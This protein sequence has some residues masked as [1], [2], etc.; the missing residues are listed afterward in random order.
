ME[1]RRPPEARRGDAGSQEGRRWKLGE[2]GQVLLGSPEGRRPELGSELRGYT[3]GL[4]PSSWSFIT[5]APGQLLIFQLTPAGPP[6]P[7][8][9]HNRVL[10]RA[11][12]QLHSVT[13]AVSITRCLEHM[14]LTGE[15]WVP[16]DLQPGWASGV[17][18][19]SPGHTPLTSQTPTERRVS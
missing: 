1:S 16:R 14:L 13:C 8:L 17:A 19:P 15:H 4:G 5:A 11:F 2:A 6:Q 9:R 12:A 3:S 7:A 18:G 10:A